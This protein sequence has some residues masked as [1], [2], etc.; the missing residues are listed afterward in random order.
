MVMGLRPSFGRRAGALLVLLLGGLLVLTGLA[1]RAGAAGIIDAARGALSSDSV[2]VAPGAEAADLVDVAKVRDATRGS[3]VEVA[4]LPAS[5]TDETS[6]RTCDSVLATF[7]GRRTYAVLCGKLFRAA[8]RVLPKG[9]AGRLATQAYK[10]H[11]VG[12]RAGITGA[13]VQFVNA[14]KS[15]PASSTGGSDSNSG[16]SNRSSSSSGGGGGGGII[17]GVLVLLGGGGLAAFFLG[18]RRR[19]ARQSQQS[20][21][22]LTEARAEVQSLYQRLGN[23]VATIDP[24]TGSAARQSMVDASERYNAAGGMLSTAT[25]IGELT[26]A[27][28][29]VVEGLYATRSV[30]ERLG[31]DPGPPVPETSSREQQL[32]RQQ[33]IEVQGQRYA[34]HPQYTPGSPYYYPGGM[35]GGGFVPGGWYGNPFWEG[36]LIG[37][38]AGGGMGMGMGWGFGGWGYGGGGYGMGYGSGY[39]SGYEEGFEEGRE[40]DGGYGGDDG[41]GGGGGGDWGGGSGGGGD[42]GGGGDFGGGGDWGGGGGDFGGGGGDGGG[43]SW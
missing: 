30:R 14:A 13:L 5:V 6:A 2:Y 31:L 9:V 15:A 11:P 29:A 25:T 22:D 4:V 38:L 7:S 32:Q 41:G 24:G 20:T 17:L 16:S 23:D 27:R 34:G 39:G 21:T 12:D 1:G 3:S 10:D 26:A 28:H 42:W 18:R 37:G 33:E 19:K 36:M 35:L 40:R 43:G 8:S